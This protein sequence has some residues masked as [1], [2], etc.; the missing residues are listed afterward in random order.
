MAK[1]PY[2]DDFIEMVNFSCQA[3]ELLL[4]SLVDFNAETILKSREEMHKIEHAEDE[5]K[6]D[7]MGRLVKEFIPPI[8]REDIIQL[9]NELDDVTDII[10]DILIRMDIYNVQKIRPAALDFVNVIVRC[11]KTLQTAMMEFHN[12]KRSTTLKQAIINV[13]SMEEDGDKIYIES[14][15]ELYRTCSDPVEIIVWSKLFDKLEE[16]CDA[17]EHVSIIMEIIIMKNS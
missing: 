8:D 12:F 1:N 7:I 13:N 16:C 17:C 2:F 4:A 5:L 9:A 6:H 14:M 11:C 15:R 10:E 3:S